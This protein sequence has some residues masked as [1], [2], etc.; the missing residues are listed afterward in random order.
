MRGGDQMR[1]QLRTF[2][3]GR[4]RVERVWL[5]SLDRADYTANDYTRLIERLSHAKPGAEAS[6]LL[7][8]S[9]HSPLARASAIAYRWDLV[10][11]R[12]DQWLRE[13]ESNPAELT[14]FGRQ[15]L[16]HKQYD[17]ASGVLESAVG[18]AP[19]HERY[20]LLAK[21]YPRGGHAAQSR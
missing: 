18:L 17:K 12:L 1:E 16:E 9:P 21:A 8:L 14:A 4:E 7:K 6:I 3:D 2:P 13:A 10:E 15:F 5:A 11:P 19:S 20:R